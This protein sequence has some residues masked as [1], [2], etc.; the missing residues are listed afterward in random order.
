MGN[1]ISQELQNDYQQYMES[2]NEIF[3]DMVTN[4]NSKSLQ[5]IRK[6]SNIGDRNS[7]ALYF[8]SYI[9]HF[10]YGNDDSL[11]PPT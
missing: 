7:Q 2:S 10:L 9:V 4:L 6:L 11:I 8:I 5:E 3:T 1:Q